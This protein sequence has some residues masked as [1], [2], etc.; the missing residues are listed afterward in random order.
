MT[1]HNFETKVLV[2]VERL[3]RKNAMGARLDPESPWPTCP[4]ILHQPKRP[5]K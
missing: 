1:K 2:R 5:R 3:T 4:Y